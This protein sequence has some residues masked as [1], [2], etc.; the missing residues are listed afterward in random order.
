MVESFGDSSI[1][2]LISEDYGLQ[3]STGKPVSLFPIYNNAI[4]IVTDNEFKL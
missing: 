2:R 4:Q 3:Y 1:I